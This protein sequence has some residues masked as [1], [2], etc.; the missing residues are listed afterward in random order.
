MTLVIFQKKDGYILAN[1]DMKMNWNENYQKPK[2]IFNLR[3]KII[4][5]RKDIL[6]CY[7][8]E[9]VHA[10]NALKK[11]WENRLNLTYNQIVEIAYKNH[12]SSRN[13]HSSETDFIISN[14][15]G[16]SCK[17]SE[18]NI[19]NHEDVCFDYIGDE[20]IFQA[21]QSAPEKPNYINNRIF[22]NIFQLSPMINSDTPSTI[23]SITSKMI[24]ASEL[25][26][27]KNDLGHILTAV[28]GD[29]SEGF[30]YKMYILLDTVAKPCKE[31]NKWERLDLGS[32][33]LGSYTYQIAPL[34]I[35]NH[36]IITYKNLYNEELYIFGNF[37]NGVP[38][39]DKCA[40]HLPT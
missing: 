35:Y 34:V 40:T 37:K 28:T 6:F 22:L 8:G 24:N 20:D 2:A 23:S 13:L 4:I 11:I 31:Q 16:S 27:K 5:I 29:I 12:I 7:A 21:Y 36:D 38:E 32:I 1:G 10:Q 9:L 14:S 18:G 15:E 26:Y 19:Y 25:Y 30:S 39:I 17:I 3:P 33:P